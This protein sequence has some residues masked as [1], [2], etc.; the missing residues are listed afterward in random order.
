MLSSDLSFPLGID[1]NNNIVKCNIPSCPHLLVC[2]VTGSGKTVGLHSMICSLL[3]STT[4]NDLLFWMFDVKMVELVKYENIPN[5]ATPVITDP[6][7]A[8][9]NFEALVYLMEKR[10]KFAQEMGARNLD[11][12]NEKLPYGEKIPYIVVV[13]DEI[14]DMM[15][16]SKHKVEESITRIAGK[17]RAVGIHLIL[18]TQSPRRE[19]ISGLLKANLPSRLGFSTSSPL[20]SR[21]IMDCMGCEKLLGQG[22]C[23]YS[24]QGRPPKRIQAPF[25]SSGEIEKVV[26]HWRNSVSD[27]EKVAA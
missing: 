1:T 26:N 7:D 9:E 14:A 15:F 10:Y 3:M 11:E 23:L 2:G 5:L 27:R 25:I 18:A 24:E 17:A 21:I 19:V 13:V 12:L 8:I 16:L 20:D 4:P 22:D 6:Y